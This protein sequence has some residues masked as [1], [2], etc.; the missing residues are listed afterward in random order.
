ME[1]YFFL[2]YARAD[3]DGAVIARFY[4]DLRAELARRDPEAGRQPSFRDVEEIFLG[5]DWER[6]LSQAISGC[7]ALVALYSPAYFASVYCGKEWT[8]FRARTA[9]YQRETGWDPGALL[10]VLWEPV[11]GGPPEPVGE[12]QYREPAMG[13]RYAELGLRRLLAEEPEGPDCRR[14][15][16]V[17]A[18]RV[19]RAAA[20]SGCPAC[21]GSTCANCRASSPSSRPLRRPANRWRTHRRPR[22]TSSSATRPPNGCGRSGR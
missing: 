10:P 7:R 17:L 20:G 18:E 8:A 9:A 19:S 2:S 13:E 15:I 11:P 4:Q 5:A 12:V 6:K 21:P 16:E 22:A 1:S 3:D 14:V